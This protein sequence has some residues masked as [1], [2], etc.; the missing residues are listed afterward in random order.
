MRHRFLK[1]YT[2]SQ[3]FTL[4]ELMIVVGILG[5]LAAIA[6]PSYQSYIRKSNRSDAIVA[7]S[8]LQ[9][10]QEKYRISN[11]T[12]GTLAQIGGASLS[13]GGY[14]TLTVPVGT[15]TAYTLVA[16]AV[17][18]K[19]QASDTECTSLTLTQTGAVTSYTPLTCWGK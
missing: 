16:T 17:T 19:A 11:T 6:L 18:T 12:Y 13:E 8:T 3:G 4:I 10:A 15:A 2:K 9:L 5:I 7:L 14:Y 1:D